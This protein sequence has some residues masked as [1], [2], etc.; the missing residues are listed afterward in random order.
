VEARLLGCCTRCL[1]DRRP[2]L[3]SRV[4]WGERTDEVISWQ[5]R[6]LCRKESRPRP[7]CT[8]TTSGAFNRRRCGGGRE[9]LLVVF[10]FRVAGMAKRSRWPQGAVSSSS[11]LRGINSRLWR[12]I[13]HSETFRCVDDYA[14]CAPGRSCV[15]QTNA[16]QE[17]V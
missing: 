5:E 7:L 2:E 10:M 3:C 15:P 11:L 8:L 14:R 6:S 13:E 17:S 4:A 1:G 12:R 16:R 9:R